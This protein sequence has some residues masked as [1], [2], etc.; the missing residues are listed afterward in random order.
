[1]LRLR[2]PSPDLLFDALLP[3]EARLLPG[4]L[5]AAGRAARDPKLLDAFAAPTGARRGPTGIWPA[6][7][8]GRPTIPMATYLRLMVLK[9]R[10]GFG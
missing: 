5:A 2:S 3:E 6:I 1:M 9:H 4:E 8:R 10:T 7:D